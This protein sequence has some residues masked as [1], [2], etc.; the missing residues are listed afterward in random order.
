MRQLCCLMLSEIKITK[1]VIS[2]G[3]HFWKVHYRNIRLI[4]GL[5]LTTLRTVITRVKCHRTKVSIPPFESS[6][7][8]LSDFHSFEHL[9]RN[10]HESLPNWFK[11]I[12]ISPSH[13]KSVHISPNRSNPVQ[14]TRRPVQACPEFGNLGKIRSPAVQIKDYRNVKFRFCGIFKQTPFQI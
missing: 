1:S 9:G 14:I 5:I 4:I 7:R 8:D 2:I 6:R 10:Q 11:S 12:Q 13:P 3:W